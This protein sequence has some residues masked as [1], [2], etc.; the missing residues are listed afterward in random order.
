MGGMP[1]SFFDHTYII[2]YGVAHFQARGLKMTIAE[3]SA[4]G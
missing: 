2:Q 3:K 4:I 1:P